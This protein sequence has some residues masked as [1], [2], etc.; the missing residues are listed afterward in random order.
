MTRATGDTDDPVP[1]RAA[2]A[3]HRGCRREG[4]R[5]ADLVQELVGITAPAAPERVAVLAGRR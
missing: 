1:R 4:D 5:L 3:D 2:G